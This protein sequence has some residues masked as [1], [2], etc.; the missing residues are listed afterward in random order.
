MS[1][2]RGLGMTYWGVWQEKGYTGGYK[3]YGGSTLENFQILLCCNQR[4]KPM[5]LL[6]LKL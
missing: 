1:K 6:L 2:G 3:G 5:G 4:F